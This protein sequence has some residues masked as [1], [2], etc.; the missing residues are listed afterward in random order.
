MRKVNCV[1]LSIPTALTCK[2]NQDEKD[3]TYDMTLLLTLETNL[4]AGPIRTLPREVT[5]QVTVIALDPTGLAVAREMVQSSTLVAN[6]S[7]S[8]V[9]TR[10]AARVAATVASVA[11]TAKVSVV[12]VEGVVVVVPGKVVASAGWW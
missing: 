2:R 6:H 1:F 9:S 7:A 11:V 8:L 12:V 3:K 4:S 10:K 5:K